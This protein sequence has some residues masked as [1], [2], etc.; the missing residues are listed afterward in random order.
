MEAND[1][2]WRGSG[3]AEL[4]AAPS[5][6]SIDS[7]K[8]AAV[9]GAAGGFTALLSAAACCVLPLAF[10]A[11]GLSS[12]AL[13]FLVPFHWPLTGGAALAVAAGWSLYAMKRRACARIP[14]RTIAPPTRAAFLALCFATA[15][16]ILSALWPGY[17]EAPLMQLLG[18]S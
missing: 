8:G 2:P 16:V 18:G 5:S 7:E 10:A 6:A 4:G 17:I 13:A 3:L 1:K 12:G 9:L 11:L 14:G 15:F